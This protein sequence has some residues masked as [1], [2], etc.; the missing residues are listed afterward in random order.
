M[1]AGPFFAL[2]KGFNP[3]RL[4][5]GLFIYFQFHPLP[6]CKGFQWIP[7]PK[8][9]ILRTNGRAP[10]SRIV[11]MPL[12]RACTLLWPVSHRTAFICVCMLSLRICWWKMK[13]DERKLGQNSVWEA[14]WHSCQFYLISKNRAARVIIFLGLGQ[15]RLKLNYF[16]DSFFIFLNL[17]LFS[18]PTTHKFSIQKSRQVLQILIWNS[19]TWMLKIWD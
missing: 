6:I 12:L 9:H 17:E 11:S 2:E 3:L 13:A 18:S 1:D 10:L 8:A 15:L 5:I 14:K 7:L 19:W 4:S 16:Y